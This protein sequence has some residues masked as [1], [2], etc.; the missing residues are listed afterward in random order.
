MKDVPAHLPDGLMLGA[1]LPRE[2]PRD[3]LVSNN[4]YTLASLPPSAIVGTSS[5]RRRA[6][7][8]R[9]RNDVEPVTLRGNVDTRL[10]KLDAGNFEAAILALAGLKRLG[11]EDRG[12]AI[13]DTKDWLPSP[14]QGA[15]GIELR[16]NDAQ[17]REAIA[18]LD[19]EPTAIA[20]A[21]ERAFLAALDGS[22]RT[23]LAALAT[24]DGSLLKFRGE[25]LALDGSEFVD[26]AFEKQFGAN[27]LE[28][29]ALWGREAGLALRPR[30]ARWLDL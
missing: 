3:V 13:L 10:A 12:T 2:D 14:A 18:K 29:A 8:L 7:L 6:Q 23:P 20:L 25:V 28:D 15:I 21:C 9:A 30:A 1:F 16:T 17:T 27:A 11:F 22:C 4:Q 26:T 5:V 24:I 19:H